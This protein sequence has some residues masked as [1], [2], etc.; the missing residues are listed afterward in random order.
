MSKLFEGLNEKQIEGVRAIDGPVLVIAAAGSGKTR[1]LTNRIAY[2]IEKGVAPEEI[3]AVTFTNKAAGE[4]RERIANLLKN[5]NSSMPMVGTF[6]SIG[7]KFL[8]AELG[9]GT[10]NSDFTIY[11]SDDQLNLIKNVMAELEIDS[12]KFN[13][14]AILARISQAKNDLAD[15]DEYADSAKEFFEKIVA[16]IYP[17]YQKKLQ[18]SN[19]MDFDDL[20]FLTVRLLQERKDI[21]EKY[22][23]Y[24]KYILVDE[25]QDTNRSQYLFLKMLAQ[26]H[27]NIMAVGDDYQGIYSFRQ[28]DIRNILSFEKDYPQAKI[29]FLEQNYRSTQNIL[30]AA[31]N[32]ISHNK[33][34]RHKNLWTENQ[35]GE[36]IFLAELDHEKAEGDFIAE[37]AKEGIRQGR[38]LNDYCVLYRIH[39]QSRAIEEALLKNGL[40][41]K[42]IGGLKFYDRKEIKDILAY[43]KIIHNPSDFLSLERIANIPARGVGKITF[44][45]LRQKQQESQ[46]NLDDFIKSY[47]SAGRQ[48]QHARLSLAEAGNAPTKT[49]QKALAGL[50]SLSTLIKALGEQ[51]QKDCLSKIIKKL[52][53][54]IEYQ[55]YLV[56]KTTE[57][58]TRWENVKELLTVT[59]KYDH[60][61]ASEALSVF[62]Q[63]VAL[64]QITDEIDPLEK[65]ITLMTIHAAKGLEFPV[66]FLAGMEEGIFPNP[67]SIGSQAELEEERRLCYV[68]ITRAKEK[69]FLTHCRSRTLYGS[70]RTNPPSQFIK[71]IPGE[72]LEKIHH[73]GSTLINRHH[74]FNYED[75]IDYD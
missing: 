51:G 36:K 69:L 26:K 25:Y 2:L 52:L 8:R 30:A 71:E 74:D 31:Q 50:A 61:K 75:F 28:A 48:V 13:P 38:F 39:A 12:K 11:D 24:F 72:Y 64:L 40:P 7:A 16:K 19:A 59:K 6:H 44:N 47:L 5:K 49:E 18:T 35:E 20:V 58:E 4:M 42:I 1:V 34:Q 15:S 33:F 17:L 3:L 10:Y 46:A 67:R 9:T 41:Y 63:E 23:N 32:I 29:I 73:R 53:Q 65:K 43:L 54:E 57:P 66:V 14:R 55:K 70:W 37:K 68:G 22:Q 45:R 56:E 27:Q 60:L 21:L 62:L